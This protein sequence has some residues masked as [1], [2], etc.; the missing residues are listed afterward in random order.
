[1]G[2][3]ELEKEQQIMVVMR[4]VLTRI[5]RETT[6]P[7]GMRHPLSDATIEDMRLCLGLI[8]AREQELL[9]AQ[10]QD[11]QARPRYVD[12]PGPKSQVIHLDSLRKQRDDEC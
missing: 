8:S 7:P 3:D 6:P 11:N 9:A 2:F 1:M 5:I 4:K 10:G 12:E